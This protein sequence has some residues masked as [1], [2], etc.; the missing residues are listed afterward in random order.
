VLTLARARVIRDE[1]ETAFRALAGP[2]PVQALQRVA[3]VV[4]PQTRDQVTSPPL[5]VVVS[6]MAGGS[7]ASMTL[8]VCR[9]LSQVQGV[10]S[11]EVALFLYTAEVFRD[12]PPDQ[13]A[14][15]EANAA[16]MIGE[17]LAAQSGAAAPGD[18]R[19]LAACGI[20]SLGG[21]EVS[22]RW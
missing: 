5:I 20:D 6:S 11:K 3:D 8:D 14:G 22:F 16:A 2:G 4:S 9:L 13:R 17:L 7:G 19:I 18:R 21:P 15:V 12:L 10:D 1:L